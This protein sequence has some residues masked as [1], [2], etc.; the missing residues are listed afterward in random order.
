MLKRAIVTGAGSGIG[1]ESARALAQS[2]V[3]L[4]LSGRRRDR[5]DA[6]AEELGA[7][8]AIVVEGDL[9]DAATCDRLVSAAQSAGDAYPVLVLCAGLATFGP[10]AELAWSTLQDQIDT[11]LVAPMR[12][13]HR[14]L[15]WL[16]VHGGQIVFVLSIAA[17]REFSGAAAYSAS[18]AGLRM[19][20]R[21]LSVE[22]RSEGVRVTSIL[23][24][25]VD[26]ELWNTQEWSPD[27]KDMLSAAAVA[28][29]IRDVVMMPL[30]RN[31]DEL[32][33]MPP[34]GIL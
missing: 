2:G 21:S 14:A 31:V 9:R 1:R 32:V 4:V 24:G 3:E 17:E 8:R 34:K 23:P 16:R 30:D 12:L 13:V 7:R 26:T 18:K 22:M 15:P 27:P 5:L 11:N 33:L 10:T 28:Q 25:S 20:A 6:L 19:F 29:V